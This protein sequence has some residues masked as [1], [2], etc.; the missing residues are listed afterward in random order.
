[1]D[2]RLAYYLDFISTWFLRITIYE[3]S[4]AVRRAKDMLARLSEWAAVSVG[5]V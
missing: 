4:L 3:A 5:C 2:V 1:M